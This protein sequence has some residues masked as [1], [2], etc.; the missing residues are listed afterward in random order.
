MSQRWKLLWVLPY[1]IQIWSRLR[2]FIWSP[3]L[4][5]VI[6]R[7]LQMASSA[8]NQSNV[9]ECKAISELPGGVS[10]VWSTVFFPYFV[11]EHQG[12][13]LGYIWFIRKYILD[14]WIGHAKCAT[15]FHFEKTE[16][17][18]PNDSSSHLIKID[19][20]GSHWWWM[21]HECSACCCP[22]QKKKKTGRVYPASQSYHVT[23]KNTKCL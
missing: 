15:V 2:A 8:S 23:L 13:P 18:F 4:P 21:F 17:C 9:D 14:P 16:N 19:A 5:E 11:L 22:S 3:F 12:T 6:I 1:L 7:F 20:F 10:F